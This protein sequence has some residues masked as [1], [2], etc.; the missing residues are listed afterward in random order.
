MNRSPAPRGAR[1]LASKWLLAL[2]LPLA[3]RAAPP[4]ADTLEAAARD[5]AATE[6]AFARAM[7]DRDFAAFG[8]LVAD[9]AVFRGRTLRIGREAVLEGWKPLFDGPVAPF[10]WRPDTVTV[11]ADGRVAV[12]TGPVQGADG[13]A[14][15]RYM[16]IWRREADGRWRIIVDQGVDADCPAAASK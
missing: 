3:V 6:R 8:A 2:A 1:S 13:S 4:T 15:G 12:S 16:S 5:V 7:A 9:D 11:S 10:S 14:S